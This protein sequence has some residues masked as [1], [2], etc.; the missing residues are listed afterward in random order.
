MKYGLLFADCA[1]MIYIYKYAKRTQTRTQSH[2]QHKLIRQRQRQSILGSTRARSQTLCA[3]TR[4]R[5]RHQIPQ[6]IHRAK[7]RRLRL[8]LR[9]VRAVDEHS[10][11]LTNSVCAYASIAAL[12]SASMKA[13]HSDSRRALRR[14]CQ[15]LSSAFE[16]ASTPNASIPRSISCGDSTLRPRTDRRS[17]ASRR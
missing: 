1:R 16:L 7:H 14:L 11:S 12:L 17:A 3:H 5:R 2:H 6:Q 9:A 4:R 8:R 13:P 10:R 15:R